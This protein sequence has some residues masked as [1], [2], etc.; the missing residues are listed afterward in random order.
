[1]KSEHPL[2][3]TS[4]GSCRK[5]MDF[6]GQTEGQNPSTARPK[7]SSSVTETLRLWQQIATLV[8]RTGGRFIGCGPSITS[9]AE[10]VAQ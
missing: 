6:T 1:M 9:L 5:G 8:H 10:V 2:I 3:S 7:G 4:A